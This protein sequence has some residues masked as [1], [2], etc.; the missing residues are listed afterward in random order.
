MRESCRT[1]HAKGLIVL[2]PASEDALGSD[3]MVRLAKWT[4]FDIYTWRIVIDLFKARVVDPRV[5]RA[6]WLA[7]ALVESAPP[8]GYEPAPAGVLDDEHRMGRFAA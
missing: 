5:Q 8:E 1:G 6:R 4:F 3:V 2:T 7:D